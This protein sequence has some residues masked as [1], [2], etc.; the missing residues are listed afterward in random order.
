MIQEKCPILIQ[1]LQNKAGVRPC[2]VFC[3][4]F[5]LYFDSRLILLRDAAVVL[6]WFVAFFPFCH[7]HFLNTVVTEKTRWCQKKLVWLRLNRQEHTHTCS[8]HIHTPMH[9]YRC[10]SVCSSQLLLDPSCDHGATSHTWK[11][12]RVTNKAD[13]WDL[14]LCVDAERGS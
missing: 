9:R 14:I 3:F 5:F 12:E 11:G 7:S 13:I 1:L 4:C 10:A 8:I 6:H 2:F